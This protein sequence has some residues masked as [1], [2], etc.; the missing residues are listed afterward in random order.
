MG[1]IKMPKYE[2]ALPVDSAN[3]KVRRN[4]IN[5]NLVAGN[6]FTRTGRDGDDTIIPLCGGDEYAGEVLPRH[7]R[8]SHD[9]VMSNFTAIISGGVVEFTGIS[10][11][12]CNWA[13]GWINGTN[14]IPLVKDLELTIEIEVPVSDSGP[15]A[16]CGMAIG[17]QL[18]P[19][20]IVSNPLL[21]DDVFMWEVHVNDDGLI[22]NIYKRIDGAAYTLLF[23]GSTY[24]DTSVRDPATDRFRIM[25]FVFHDS[26]SGTAYRHIHAYMK[27]GSSRVLAEAAT[28]NELSTSPYDTS[29]LRFLVAY[30]SYSV[31]SRNG[32]YFATGNV[33]ASTYFRADYPD[34]EILY[35]QADA[36]TGKND[37][38]LWDSR[39]SVTESDW[40]QVYDEDHGFGT[41]DAIIQNGTIRLYIDRAA[42]YGLELFY[43]NGAAWAQPLDQ[44]IFRLADDLDW[45]SYPFVT[46]IEKISTEEIIVNVRVRESATPDDDKYLD[47]KITLK[48]GAMMIE[49]DLREVYPI[50]DVRVVFM[51]ST[52]L[53]F[54]YVQDDDIGDDDLNITVNNATMTD[55]FLVAFDDAGTAVLATLSI[56][57]E[58]NTQF[59]ADDGGSIRIL[60][61]DY[62]DLDDTI[63]YLGLTPFTDIAN[64]FEEAEDATLFGGATAV[65]DGAASGGQAALL[66]AQN[67]RVS[68]D[69]TA[70]TTLP[71]GRYIVIFRIRDINQVANDVE[72]AAYNTTDSVF[73]NQENA[74]VLMTATAAYAFYGLVFDITA[75]DEAG[76]DTIILYVLKDLVAA[77]EIYVDDILIIPISNGEDWPLD[78]SHATQRTEIDAPRVFEK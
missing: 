17:F 45:L 50:Q 49:F 20:E 47:I 59:T 51:D 77:N 65:A 1:Y 12:P 73:R 78:I 13:Y 15:P 31:Q 66:N 32:T 75:M 34:F 55:N 71:G 74:A 52:Q 6:T 4:N 5:Y 54:G 69:I 27:Q 40:R 33:G 68:Y 11:N 2:I 25:R 72:I 62:L 43:W 28:E 21:Q 24:D 19:N 63:V 70:G 7:W 26:H 39:G 44:I 76:G 41:Y 10:N 38:E 18:I 60:D 23:D 58:P 3:I 35:E 56:N 42:Q 64:L 53:R 16:A 36:D 30:P 14:P 46:N 48:R 37:V 22:V 61:V 29:D 67:E 9:G 8:K 57:E